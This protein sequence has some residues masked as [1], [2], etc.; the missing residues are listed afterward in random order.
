MAG[1]EETGPMT[2]HYVIEISVKQVTWPSADGTAR[3]GVGRS[4]HTGKA[5]R[6]VALLSRTVTTASEL[7]AAV[8]KA[9]RLL[10][11]EMG[12]DA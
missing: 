5:E 6:R 3:P 8:D 2:D 7:E 11:V 9:K 10:A 1:Q 12:E 4:G